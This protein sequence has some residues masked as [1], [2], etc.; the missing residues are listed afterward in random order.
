MQDD[1]PDHAEHRFDIS[2]PHQTN[3]EAENF[4]AAEP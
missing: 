3:F 1:S 4:F 2:V